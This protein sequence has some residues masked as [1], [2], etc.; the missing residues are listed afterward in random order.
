MNE[1]KFEHFSSFGTA[2]KADRCDFRNGV[3]V[4]MPQGLPAE[5]LMS[6]VSEMIGYH[7]HHVY[8]NLNQ[9]S[10]YDCIAYK[11]A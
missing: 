8:P 9:F 5:N 10:G 6:D 1:Q 7:A 11:F 4:T 2:F 3:T